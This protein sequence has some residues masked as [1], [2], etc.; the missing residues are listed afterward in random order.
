MLDDGW[1][2]TKYPRNYDTAGLGD[3]KVNE[4]KVKGGLEKMVKRIAELRNRRGDPIK[5]G[6]W[7]EPEH[8]NPSSELYEAHPDWALHPG[9]NGKEY[10]RK[11]SR[12]QLTLNLSIPEVQNYLI[13]AI[14]HVLRLA[15]ISYVKW[16]CNRSI[17]QLATPA[18]GHAYILG[19]YRV[20]GTLVDRFPDVLWVGCS[21]GGGRFDPGMLHWFPGS[22]T[23]DNT[24]PVDRLGIQT[25]T[26]IVYP[27]SSMSGHVSAVPNH[28]TNRE[29]PLRFRAHVAMLCGSFGLEL[30]P[31]DFTDADRREI[32]Q[33]IELSERISPY[34]VQGDLY[35][36]ARPDK[37]NW[38]AFLYVKP[39]GSAVLLAYQIHSSMNIIPPSVR[40]QGLDQG[41]V[42]K[43]DGK[44]Y[45]GETLCNAGLRMEWQAAYP[46]RGGDYQSK[47]L[48]LD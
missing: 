30:D 34:I 26:S 7:V 22:W 4:R 2:G 44:E 27:P 6:L 32:S 46:T 19:L 38:P 41:R 48:F 10:P 23:S 16:D 3:W 13:D 5:F 14:D 45:T 40:L 37:S 1:F 39:D 11:E 31:A 17:Q 25:G 36:L 20:I 28:Q 35:R 18:E 9:A 33:Y 42:Y 29:T 8:V 21:G 43:V 15:K 24:D 12:N 47:V